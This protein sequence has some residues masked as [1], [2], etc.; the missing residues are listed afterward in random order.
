MLSTKILKHRQRF[1]KNKIK[2][3][4]NIHLENTNQNTI[5]VW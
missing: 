3:K 1:V 2:K 5:R 4:K